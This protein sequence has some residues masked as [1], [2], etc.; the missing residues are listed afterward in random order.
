VLVRARKGYNSPL[1]LHPPLTFHKG[2]SHVLDGGSYTSEAE[3]ILREMK[4]LL[5]DARLSGMSS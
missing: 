4:E 3:T 2:S 5:P 1:T